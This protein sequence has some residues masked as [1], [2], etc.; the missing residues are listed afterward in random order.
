MVHLFRDP[1]EN[2]ALRLAGRP[3]ALAPAAI[4]IAFGERN[5]IMTTGYAIPKLSS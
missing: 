1:L 5:A 3:E 4:F 2:R